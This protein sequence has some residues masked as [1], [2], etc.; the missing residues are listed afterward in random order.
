MAYI[1]SMTTARMRAARLPHF[2]RLGT[3]N[4]G[5][6]CFTI[7]MGT[8]I[9]AVCL[10]ISPVAVPFGRATG[11]ALWSADAVLFALLALLWLTNIVRG[12]KRTLET[13]RDPVKAQ[14]WGAP[15]MACFT[16]AVGALKIGELFLPISTCVL[17]AQVL[18]AVGVIGSILSVS[19]VPYLMFT[20]HELS[21]EKTFGSWLLPVVPPIVAS[22]PAALLS[23]TWPASFRGDVLGLA[24]ALLGI[25][26]ILAAIIIV[27]F[28]SRL[29]YNKV[30][31]GA[32]V[33][34]MWLVVGPLGQSVAGMI[35]LGKA[36]QVVWPQFGQGLAIA[37]LAYGVLVWGFGMYWLAMAIALTIRAMRRHLP[38][39]L[40]WWA[41]TF[42]VGV[43]T[44]GTDALYVVTRAHI[45]A[46]AS[47]GLVALLGTM[48][49]LVAT[50]TVRGA[51]AAVAASLRPVDAASGVKIQE[52]A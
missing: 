43:L 27:I 33:T 30:P 14:L 28:Y 49:T 15:P 6:G 41:F 25:G 5:P 48:W 31:D 44:V 11:V 36:A 47:V 8:G 1:V 39:N 18:F 23:S 19:V 3:E 32:L 38:F 4:V 24:Y 40:S 42:P 22:V 2:G 29:L 46:L 20:D 10:T 51:L 12:P 17:T 50:K 34:T 52:V 37:G 13:L 21:E 45:F 35:A 7:V 9:L 26:I 16:I